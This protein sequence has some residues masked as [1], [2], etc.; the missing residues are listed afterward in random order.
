MALGILGRDRRL[1]GLGHRSDRAAHLRGLV[2]QHRSTRAGADEGAIPDDCERLLA[3]GE[4]NALL[5]LPLDTVTVRSTLGVAEPSVGR[6]E[7]VACRYTTKAAGPARG[8]PLLMLN[9]AS[10]TSPDAASQ[11]WRRN[12]DIEDGVHRDLPIG[13]AGAVLVERGGEAL[14]SVVYG[15]ATLTLILPDQPL[16][17]GR[18]RT[19]ALVDLALRV[20]PAVAPPARAAATTTPPAPRPA[21]PPG[22]AT[23]RCR[24]PRRPVAGRR[25]PAPSGTWPR[26]AGGADRRNRVRQVDRGAPAGAATAR[27]LIDADVLAREVVEPGTDGLAEIVDGV[28]HRGARRRRCAGPAGAGR[29]GVRRP[30][31]PGAAERHRAPAGAAPV[32]PS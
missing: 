13:S 2:G 16:P 9:A 26:A 11:Q 32:R 17:G 12:A 18:P 10:Y 30:G 29:G 1:L 24:R 3:A 27:C 23:T 15:P 31:R 22:P 21:P 4:L 14:L 25:W 19:E 28:R 6:T 5:G 8:R 7:R 20:L